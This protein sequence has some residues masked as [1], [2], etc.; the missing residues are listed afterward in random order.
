MRPA[1]DKRINLKTSYA[2]EITMKRMVFFLSALA[3]VVAFTGCAPKP[4]GAYTKAEVEAFVAED[5]ERATG[6]QLKG[7]K[8]VPAKEKGRFVGAC[9]N[10]D[11]L[12]FQ[13]EVTQ[14]PDRI[15][16]KAVHKEMTFSG[17]KDQ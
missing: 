12:P 8:L 9:V 17:S 1:R 11:G 16:R 2:K 13:V 5:A 14:E 3:V 6:L 10:A 15:T 4:F 7:F